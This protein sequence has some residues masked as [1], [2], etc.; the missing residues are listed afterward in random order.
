MSE[1]D[2]VAPQAAIFTANDKANSAA[3]IIVLHED[4]AE[5]GPP[6]IPPIFQPMKV[7]CKGV[8]GNNISCGTICR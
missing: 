7:R 2:T 3:P 8:P 1:H 4:V 5:S 6:S